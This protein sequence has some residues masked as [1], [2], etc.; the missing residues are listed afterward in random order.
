MSTP[1]CY[2]SPVGDEDSL[3]PAEMT[4]E[5]PERENEVPIARLVVIV[6]ESHRLDLVGA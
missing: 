5:M 2:E 6:K 3:S 4:A 1:S